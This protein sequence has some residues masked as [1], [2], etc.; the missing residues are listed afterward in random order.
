MNQITKKMILLCCFFSALTGC[1]IKKTTNDS[2]VTGTVTYREPISLSSAAEL[3]VKILDVSLQDVAAIELGATTIM[4]PGQVPIE[5]EVEYNRADIIENHRYAVRATIYE[6]GRMRFTTDTH[7]PV[8]TN[9][10]G[11][12]VSIM[13]IAVSPELGIG[14]QSLT[15][16]RWEL[17]TAYDVDYRATEDQPVPF[18]LLSET[19]NSIKGSSG[20]NNFAGTYMLSNNTLQLGPLAM[21]MMA[22]IDNELMETERRFTQA[23]DKMDRY[24]ISGD[25]LTGYE[26]DRQILILE[27][28]T[29]AS[30]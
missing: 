24:E 22:C 23:L 19:N 16:T 1:A 14:T 7:Y 6:Q 20:C 2:R 4:N 28:S 15:E 10:A 29:Q 27:A 3:E 17:I 21:T 26:G 30:Q 18:I 5:F 11:T 12:Q 25:R 13:M 9:G 8:L